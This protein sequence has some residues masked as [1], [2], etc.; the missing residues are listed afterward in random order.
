M[1][2]FYLD[3]DEDNECFSGISK[4]K[5]KGR[6]VII[7]LSVLSQILFSFVKSFYFII[8]VIVLLL[9]NKNDF[10]APLW[11]E[12]I[13]LNGFSFLDISVV[14]LASLVSSRSYLKVATEINNR[15]SSFDEGAI[16]WYL[17]RKEM[18]IEQVSF[19]LNILAFFLAMI[20][21]AVPLKHLWAINL[22]YFLFGIN[23]HLQSRVANSITSNAL[24]SYAYTRF[25]LQQ[26]WLKSEN[27]PAVIGYSSIIVLITLIINGKGQIHL[28]ENIKLLF[29]SNGTFHIDI[30]KAFAAGVAGYHLGLST[31]SYTL[32]LKEIE[33]PNVCILV[34]PAG[35]RNKMDRTVN[36][37]S[38]VFVLFILFFVSTFCVF[39][40]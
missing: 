13:H 39:L 4:Y 15:I 12:L 33:E 19:I 37:K 24:S 40:S 7:F 29:F 31:C 27:F 1:Q 26:Q 11:E 25:H 10:L 28:S 14:F 9:L 22:I 6:Y 36:S 23:N 34:D 16:D 35:V 2:R 8:I 38:L 30:I 5:I 32:G 3:L 18:L 21:I 20:F 17:L